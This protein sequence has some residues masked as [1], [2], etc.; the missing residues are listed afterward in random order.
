M[1]SSDLTVITE[2]RGKGGS[3]SVD[4][5]KFGDDNITY[6]KQT[7]TN[8]RMGLRYIQRR[9]K[10]RLNVLQLALARASKSP[11]NTWLNAQNRGYCKGHS[12]N[13]LIR[14]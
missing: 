5:L 9:T 4:V 11:K 13:W 8:R 1:Q 3:E 7:L 10:G 12:P 2:S 14:A 6:L